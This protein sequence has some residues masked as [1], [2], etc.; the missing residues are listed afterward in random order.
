MAKTSKNK[1]IYL[2]GV[3]GKK[4]DI[5][6]TALISEIE[7]S[8][9]SGVR[10][11][12][13]YVNSEGGEVSQ[14]SSLYNYLERT[15]IGVTWVVDGLAASMAAMLLCSPKHTVKAA[16]HAKFMYHKVWGATSGN[17]TEV[18]A[19]ADMIDTFE[20]SLVEM[21]A[22]RMERSAEEVKATFFDGSD[23]WLSAAEAKSLGLVD[24]ILEGGM[25][26][27]MPENV[28]SLG[29]EGVYNFYDKQIRQLRQ[30]E[31]S[32]NVYA[33]ALGLSETEDDSAALAHLQGIVSQNRS[34]T[35]ELKAEKEKATALENRIRTLE[36]DKVKSL[37]EKAIAERKITAEDRA[38]YVALAEKDYAS[39]EKILN[40]MTGVSR[41]KGQL[42]T[43][44]VASKYE[45]KS[46]DELDKAGRLASLRDELPELYAQLYA[47]KFGTAN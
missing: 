40:K 41:I 11:F 12:V 6:T 3:I 34:L 9:K 27:K 35:E 5:D 1:E 47:E 2:Y 43:Q 13:F 22:A 44:G 36:G 20:A 25:E 28:A 37:V 14:G 26:L 32:K 29:S 18:R 33:V 31:Q 30:M 42:N 23:H 7:T 4:K 46:W 24:E 16:R 45:G 38:T 17:S 10:D 8:R 15:D 21:M 19:Y 39:V